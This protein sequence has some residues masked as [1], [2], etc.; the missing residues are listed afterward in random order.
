MYNQYVKIQIDCIIPN[1]RSQLWTWVE[2]QLKSHSSPKVRIL[3]STIYT[4]RGV[5]FNIE[6]NLEKSTMEA[7]PQGFIH[8]VS[9]LHQKIDVYSFRYNLFSFLSLIRLRIKIL[10][11]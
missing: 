1:K 5:K 11:C 10:I 2:A 3:N 7:A 6:I 8:Q 9:T 4:I